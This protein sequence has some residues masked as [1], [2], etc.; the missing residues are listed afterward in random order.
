VI[1]PRCGVRS[2]SVAEVTA[3]TGAWRF[4]P[5]AILRDQP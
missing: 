4:L 1:M 3:D 5:P 2:S